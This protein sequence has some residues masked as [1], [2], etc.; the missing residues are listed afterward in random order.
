SPGFGASSSVNSA[1]SRVKLTPASERERSQQEIATAVSAR[2]SEMTAA[3]AFV[4]QSPSIGGGR[5]GQPV[6]FVIQAPNFEKLR[7]ALP[8]FLDRAR[9]DPTF[10]VV[11]VDLKFN[12]PELVVDIDRARAQDLGVSARDIG[13]TL[14]AAL[15]GQRFGFFLRDGKQYW[16]IGQLLRENRD[17]PLDLASLFVKGAGGQLVQLDSLVS[18]REE[19]APPQIYRFDRYVSATVSASL[20]PEQTVGDGIEAMRGVA[21]EVLD[22]SF[23]TALAGQSKDFEESASSLGFIFLLALMLIYLVLSAQFESFRDPLVIML[24][25]P[26]ALAGA[27]MALALFGQSLNI[28]SQIGLIMLLGLVTKNGILIVEFANQRRIG[29]DD[30]MDAIKNAAAARFRPVLMTSLSTV[31]GILPIALALGAGA[32]SRRSMGIAVIGGLVIG[33]ALTL[34]VIPAMYSYLASRTVRSAA[35]AGDEATAQESPELASPEPA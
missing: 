2:L 22:D 28:F 3:R 5:R 27:L 31:L 6:Q 34:Y 16:V 10:S 33:G 25:V 23:A 26:L 1:F 8:V 19:A 15:S 30:L 9:Q 35:A 17:D 29:G 4:T 14:T 32:E 18:L 20:A 12:K 11:T 13:E 7:E 24:T 21:K